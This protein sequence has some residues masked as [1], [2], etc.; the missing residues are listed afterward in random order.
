MG[1]VERK[2]PALNFNKIQRSVN[3]GIFA[4]GSGEI[5][6][7]GKTVTKIYLKFNA[8]KSLSAKLPS[9]RVDIITLLQ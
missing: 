2:C 6:F 9:Y 7:T 4:D 3:C 5:D 8:A 1:Y